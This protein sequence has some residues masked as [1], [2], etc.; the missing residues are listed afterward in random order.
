MEAIV[1][2]DNVKKYFLGLLKKRSLRLLMELVL[3][4]IRVK[5]LGY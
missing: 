5:F 3:K 4:L 2:V 1:K